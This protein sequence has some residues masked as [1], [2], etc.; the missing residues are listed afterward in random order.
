MSQHSFGFVS[1]L[2][3]CAL[4]TLSTAMG[5][6]PTSPMTRLR[7]IG[8]P[9]AVDRYRGSA[10]QTSGVLQRESRAADR[11]A[12]PVESADYR[13][14]AYQY[15]GAN[16]WQGRQVHDSQVRQTAMQQPFTAPALPGA[17]SGDF[18][19]PGAAPPAETIVPSPNPAVPS[20]VA[21]RG[22]PSG[23]VLSPVPGSGSSPGPSVLAPGGGDFAPLA[24]PELSNSFATIDNCNC[25]SGPSGYTGASGTGGCATVSYETPAYVAPIA[26]TPAPYVA[27][28]AQITAPAIL[29]GTVPPAGGAPARSLV[30]F[31]QETKPVQVGQGWYGQPVAYVPGQPIRN[32]FRYLFP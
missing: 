32:W 28:P 24:Q 2:A 29:P 15:A 31:G 18:A 1:V 16:R 22:L 13:E 6:T 3:V 14:T 21:P 5:Q 25:V 12:S 10:D 19:L 11:Y 23:N 7:P 9:S 27:P 20:Q 30:T 17:S 4:T 8:E 26:Q